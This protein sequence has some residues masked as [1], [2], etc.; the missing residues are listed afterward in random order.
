ML[1]NE[2]RAT[3]SKLVP[4][5]CAAFGSV[6]LL[7]PG[8]KSTPTVEYSV[9]SVSQEGGIRFSPVTDENDGVLS[10]EV[11]RVGQRLVKKGQKHFDI[12]RDGTKIAYL[13]T[14]DKKTNIYVRNLALGGKATVQRTFRDNISDVA[15]SPDGKLVAFT[16]RREGNMNIYLTSAEA[17]SAI[18]QVTSSP[19]NEFQPAFSPDG[20]SLLYVQSEPGAKNE[21]AKTVTLSSAFMWVYDIA[22]GTQTQY[23]E[24]MNADF[25][26]DSKKVVFSRNNKETGGTELWMLELDTGQEILVSSDKYRGYLDPAIS[27]DGNKIAFVSG[28][29]DRDDGEDRNLDIFIVNVDG[30]NLTQLT[31]HPGDDVAPRWGPDGRTIFFLSQ[32]GSTDKKWNIWKMELRLDHFDLQTAPKAPDVEVRPLR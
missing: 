3:R 12:S 27:P 28:S 18:R 15:M 7:L 31:F 6:A 2:A 23:A 17:G 13:A 24:G 21:A 10:P 8:C 25:A 4:L 30:S 32:R 26:P 19:L 9:V 29:R 22:R 5:A 20:R 14:R 11:T 16:D 1:R